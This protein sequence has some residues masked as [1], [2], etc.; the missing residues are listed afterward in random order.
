MF[1]IF[2]ESRFLYLS[3]KRDSGQRVQVRE[4]K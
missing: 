4:S 2:E 1:P 3:K